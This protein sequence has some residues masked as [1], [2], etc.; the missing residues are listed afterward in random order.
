MIT[1][2]VAAGDPAANEYYSGLMADAKFDAIFTPEIELLT[3]CVKSQPIDLILFDLSSPNLSATSWLEAVRQDS[4]LALTPVL[5]VGMARPMA[6]ATTLDNY[7]PGARTRQRPNLTSLMEFVQKLV[8]GNAAPTADDAEP[9]ESSKEWKPEDDTIDDALSIFADAGQNGRSHPRPLPEDDDEDIFQTSELSRTGP[10]I[11]G[12]THPTGSTPHTAPEVLAIP[13][14]GPEEKVVVNL[15]DEG[16]GG[17]SPSATDT[18]D[19]FLEPDPTP[20]LSDVSDE[21]VDE[22]TNKVISRL[23]SEV[24]KSLD[25]GAIRQT[26]RE[27]LSEQSR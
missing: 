2:A 8:A 17:D 19:L 26:V 10:V 5:W 23:A 22:I 11:N 27:V 16:V 21:L 9:I 6:L 7:R 18:S 25:A 3:Q 13:S 20:G 24:F 15:P 4:A 14:S 1:V 12:K